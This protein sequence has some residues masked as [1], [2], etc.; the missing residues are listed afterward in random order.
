MFG[1]LHLN[2]VGQVRKVANFLGKRGR[3]H[4]NEEHQG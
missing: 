3:K 1:V 4:C 2:I